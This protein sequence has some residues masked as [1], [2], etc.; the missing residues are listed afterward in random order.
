M[1]RKFIKGDNIEDC[2]DSID[3]ILQSWA[4]RLGTHIIGI[5]P[6]VPI[7]A[8]Q[9]HADKDGLIFAGVLPF[10]GKIS[11]AFLVIGKYNTK[12]VSVIITMQSEVTRS[13]ATIQADKPIIRYQTDILVNTGDVV[14]VEVIPAD[15]AE[16]FLI[17]FLCYPEM[18]ASDKE[19]RL[20]S[21]LRMLDSMKEL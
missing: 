2:L 6:P 16:E 12:P 14:R 8:H 19:A 4:P 5:M 9:H 7:L 13:G 1:D 15:G 21:E 10:T 3:L 20:I 18:A 11:T 17:G